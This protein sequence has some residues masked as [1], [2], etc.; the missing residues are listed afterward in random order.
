[1]DTEWEVKVLDN[2][3][4]EEVSLTLIQLVDSWMLIQ[5][6]GEG[7]KDVQSQ[8]LWNLVKSM[9]TKHILLWNIQ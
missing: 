9:N 8:N 4:N 2:I 7:N 5:H 3:M 6:G 1:M